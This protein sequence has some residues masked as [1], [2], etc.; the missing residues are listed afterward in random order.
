MERV[1]AAT[2]AG[3]IGTACGSDKC[4][5]VFVLDQ[6]LGAESD[7]GIADVGN[8]VDTTF[9]EPATNDTQAEVSLVLMIG[10]EQFNLDVGVLGNE[11]VDRLL[12]AG[13]AGR[14]L[15]VAI[16]ACHIGNVADSDRIGCL[17]ARGACGPDDTGGS[18]TASNKHA[19][20]KLHG[21]LLC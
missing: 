17:R 10:N 6:C 21:Y 12:R 8:D 20:I 7:G 16:D 15:Y 14:P 18:Q 5:L 3:E 19:T 1:R 4:D 2:L 13:D 9:I 11:L